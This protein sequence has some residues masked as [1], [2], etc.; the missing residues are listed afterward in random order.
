MSKPPF[1]QPTPGD[2]PTTLEWKDIEASAPAMVA[3]FRAIGPTLTESGL[4]E[5]LLE[6][7]KVRVSQINACAF[8]LSMHLALARRH[9]VEQEKLDLLATWRETSLF[10]P[11]ERA[12]LAWAEA[13][14]RLADNHPS[15]ELAAELDRWFNVPQKIALTGAIG[16]INA[17]NRLMVGM[18]MQPSTQ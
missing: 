3:A 10:H 13:L 9:G 12:A 2:I 16:L 1:K 18:G 8:C 17:W 5:A 14:T 6:L 11:Q 4:T 15:H 7:V